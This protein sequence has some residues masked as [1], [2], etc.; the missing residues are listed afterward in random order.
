MRRKQAG[1]WTEVHEQHVSKDEAKG[2]SNARGCAQIDQNN[3]SQIFN[4]S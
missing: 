2:I 3:K 1:V 4:G